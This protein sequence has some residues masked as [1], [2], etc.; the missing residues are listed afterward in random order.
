MLFKG[1]ISSTLVGCQGA[2]CVESLAK[3]PPA[4][5]TAT[6]VLGSGSNCSR[7]YVDTELFRN[8][9]KKM[10]DV[11]LNSTGLLPIWVDNGEGRLSGVLGS[12]K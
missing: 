8:D 6:L 9:F 10:C 5:I 11:K 7:E 4:L 1:K 3:W 2:V 12:S